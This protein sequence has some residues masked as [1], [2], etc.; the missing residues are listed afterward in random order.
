MSKPEYKFGLTED[1]LMELRRILKNHIK[2]IA[3][4]SRDRRPLH[5]LLV[6]VEEKLKEIAWDKYK[7]E[8]KL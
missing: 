4:T 2:S 5:N 8:N 1:E 7:K 6:H 3:V